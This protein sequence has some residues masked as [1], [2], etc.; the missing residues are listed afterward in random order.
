MQDVD[1][2][3]PDIG[4][5]PPVK[6]PEPSRPT[7]RD[8]DVYPAPAPIQDPPLAPQEPGEP[9]PRIDDPLI[10]ERPPGDTVVT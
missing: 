4:E 3:V 8:P 1:T 7:E 2:P 5:G 6:E 9:E 10:P